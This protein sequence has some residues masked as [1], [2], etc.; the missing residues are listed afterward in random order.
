[1]VVKDVNLYYIGYQITVTIFAKCRLSDVPST[2][3]PWLGRVSTFTVG[4]YTEKNIQRD[5]KINASTKSLISRL[6]DLK[7]YALSVFSFI[8]SL[9]ALEKRYSQI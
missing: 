6:C 1:M 5:L 7:I 3:A 2:W 9:C 8:G 4:R